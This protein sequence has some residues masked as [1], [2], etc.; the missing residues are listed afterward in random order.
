MDIFTI[1][2]AVKL[3][4]RYTDGVALN[5]V[6]VNPPRINAVTKM[7]QL[8]DPISGTYVDTIY[9]AEGKDGK[10]PSIGVNNNWFIDGVDT[11]VS[12]IGTKGDDGREIELDANTEFIVWRYAGEL[13]WRNLVPL[14]LLIGADGKVPE[15][16]MDGRTLQ[17]RYIDTDPWADL[18]SFPVGSFATP[19][20][21][22][23]SLVLTAAGT[24]TATEDGFIQRLSGVTHPSTTYITFS[25]TINGKSLE[26]L[27][28][29]GLLSTGLY[30]WL[31]QPFPVKAGDVVV[32][33]HKD[34][35]TGT[36]VDSLTFFPVIITGGSGGEGG[37]NTTESITVSNEIGGWKNND[38]IPVGT[39]LE[40]ILKK[41]LN[42]VI[43]PTYLAPTLTL[44]GTTPLAREIGENINITLTPTFTQ[45]DGGAI[46]QYRLS[47]DGTVLYT[48]AT[49]IPQNDALQ[50]I[51]NT[52]YQAA[53]DYAQGA[54]KQ[55]SAGNDDPNG[56]IP[57]GT[58]T[59]GNVIYLPQRRSFFGRLIS[60]TVPNTN[61]LVR[62]LTQNALNS[63][64]NT[65]MVASVQAGDRGVCFA[66]PATLRAPT[67]ITQAGFMN[68]DV[69]DAFTEIT[70]TVEGANGYSP[71]AYRVL[72]NIN[73][74]PFS[75]ND[76]FTLTV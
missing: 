25:T 31:S 52:T 11:G 34:G 3:A 8:F 12:A 16:N 53:A 71:I 41:M 17:Y 67:S 69:K 51:A 50:L 56:R 65:V 61:A 14:Y 22:N 35:G 15:F 74:L 9:L 2:R 1:K 18:Y 27:E 55:D 68:M 29:Q 70:V 19:D 21:N 6:P 58:V 48:G 75:A 62:A 5:G 63:Q 76:T 46:I 37:G 57:A 23:P 54:I 33:S 10:T 39:A 66:Y 36:I 60:D 32:T 43:P 59:S 38:V 24:Y 40:A 64:N 26:V 42:P 73:D 45:R 49:A 4:R 28:H 13:S 44:A 30:N 7:W 20:W 47:K 72:Y